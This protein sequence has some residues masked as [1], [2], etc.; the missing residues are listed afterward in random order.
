G[1]HILAHGDYDPD[2]G[3]GSLLLE[4][5]TGGGDRINDPELQSWLTPSL[6]LIVFQ[7][8]LSAAT[9]AEGHAPFTGLAPRL[10]RLGLPAAI[11]MQDFVE[12]ED[13]RVFFSEFYRAILDDGL[14]DVA[15]NRG[16]QGLV[17]DPRR[18]TPLI[19]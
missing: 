6:Q 10:V 18:D 2:A 9:G 12:M 8:C 4:N 19:P 7:A 5:A 3:I 14:V 15:V 11:A 16:R 1:L 17:G 13:A